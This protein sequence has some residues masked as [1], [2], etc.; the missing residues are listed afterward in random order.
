MSLLNTLDILAAIRNDIFLKL[1]IIYNK[2]KMNL[3]LLRGTKHKVCLNVFDG[4]D[5]SDK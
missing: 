5:D 1:M 3:T 4:H 2:E